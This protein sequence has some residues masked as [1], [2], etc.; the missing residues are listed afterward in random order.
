MEP[1]HESLKGKE[2]EEEGV[3]AD[4][5]Q[6]GW[7]IPKAF[8]EGRGLGPCRPDPPRSIEAEGH[9]DQCIFNLF[10]GGHKSRHSLYL[11][12]VFC[13]GELRYF[14]KRGTLIA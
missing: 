2:G 8:D 1:T 7:R 12:S 11:L 14:E 13:G 9:P 5:C 6:G 10:D 3:I 4:V